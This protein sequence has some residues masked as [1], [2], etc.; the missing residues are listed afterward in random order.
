MLKNGAVGFN[1]L[2]V[3]AECSLFEHSLA[4][5]PPS[6]SHPITQ[7]PA[8]G[9]DTSSMPRPRLAAPYTLVDPPMGMSW[10]A[11]VCELTES[12]RDAMAAGDFER[13]TTCIDH[14]FST[15]DA[16]DGAN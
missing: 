14:A 9:P 6:A 5:P 11:R 4:M 7:P 3:V 15:V 16:N 1:A 2:G 12:A 10:R 13:A 8:W